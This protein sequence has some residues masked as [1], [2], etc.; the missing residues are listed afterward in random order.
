MDMRDKQSYIGL[1]Q[2]IT[3]CT[4]SAL[5]IVTITIAILYLIVVYADVYK[6]NGA[7]QA[8]SQKGDETNKI[9]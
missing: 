1:I 7:L 8:I 4:H 9:K 5:I 2:L 6:C 3:I